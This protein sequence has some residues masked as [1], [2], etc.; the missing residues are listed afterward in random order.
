M[1]LE[2][3]VTKQFKFLDI[4]RR[5]ITVDDDLYDRRRISIE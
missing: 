5:G 2:K 4:A 3:V 1:N